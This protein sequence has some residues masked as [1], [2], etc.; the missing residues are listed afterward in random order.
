MIALPAVDPFGR[1]ARQWLP[2]WLSFRLIRL[3]FLV[4]P[5]MFFN[6][7]RSFP[8]A[9]RFI[10]RRSTERELKRK[11]PHDPHFSPRYN[12]WEQRLCVC[13]DGD[14]FK[15]LE[16]GKGD[17][18]TDTIREVTETGIETTNGTFLPADIVVTAT[19]LKIAIGGGANITVDGK[20]FVIGEK[21]FWKGLMLQDLPNL[22]A[23]IGYTNASW[24]LGADATAMHVTRLLKFMQEKGYTSAVPTVEDESKI[25][26]QP[27]LNLNSTYV[28]K[29]K[30]DMPKAGDVAPWKPRSS[31]FSDYWEAKHGDITNGLR[32]ESRAA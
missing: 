24:T 13:P 27:V 17:I 19:G 1:W 32:F 11:F 4:L 8:R 21:F 16:S 6:F 30:A 10:M 23:V 28:E 7:C 15:A 31:Y 29:A 20:P 14:F 25:G 9:A 22:A 2:T 12:P 3:K 18:V 26:V 5:F